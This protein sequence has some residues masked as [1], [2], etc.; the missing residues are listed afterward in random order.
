[1]TEAYHS[2]LAFVKDPAFSTHVVTREEYLESGS[3]ASRRKFPGWQSSGSG[4]PEI[5]KVVPES[6]NE[7]RSQP[8]RKPSRPRMRTNTT[9]G[10]RR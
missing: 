2:A 6:M 5:T 9:S 10:R 8:S 3:S 4:D 1:V 7:E